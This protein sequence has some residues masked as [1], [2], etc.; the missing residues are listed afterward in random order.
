VRFSVLGSLR[1]E[2]D[3]AVDV[4]GPQVGRLLAAL[5]IDAGRVVTVDRLADIVFAGQPTDAAST[6]LRSYVGRLRRLLVDDGTGVAVVTSR[7]GYRLELGTSTVDAHDFESCLGAARRHLAEGDPAHALTEVD[8]GLALWRGPAYA[9]HADEEWARLEALRLEE[10]RVEGAELRLRTLVAGGRHDAAVADLG[11]FVEEHPLREEAWSALVVA[12]HR[13][14]RQ[15]EALRAAARFRRT[16][17]D[18]GLDPSLAFVAL[19][20]QV[21]QRDPDLDAPAEPARRLRGYRVV[22]ELARGRHGP[23]CLAVQPGVER[24]VVLRSFAA[25]VADH[26]DFIRGFPALVQHVARIDHPHVIPIQDFWREPGAAHLVTRY[27]RGGTAR[28]LLAKGPAPVERVTAIVEHVAGAL[29]AAHHVGL[30]HGALDAGEV[31]FDDDGNAYVDGMGVVAMLDGLAGADGPDRFAVAAASDQRS[32]ADLARHA[33]T[34]EATGASGLLVS[35]ARPELLALDGVFARATAADPADRYPDIVAF[36]RS[37]A[38]AVGRPTP[39]ARL[40]VGNPYKGLR[41]FAEADAGEFFGRDRA[42]AEV[43]GRLAERRF[44]TVVGASGSGK[45][46]VVRAGLVPLVRAGAIAGSEHWYVATM[47][48]GSD[49]F[50]AWDDALGQIAAGGSG[51]A[52]TSARHGIATSLRRAVP[53]GGDVLVVVDQLEELFTLVA[54]ETVRR[55]FIDGL[56]AA[57]E[58]DGSPLRVVATLRADLYD[59]PLGHHRFGGLV[60]GGAV[61]LVGMSASELERAIVG[62]AERAGVTFDGSLVA[63]LVAAVADRPGSLPLLEFTLT[64]LFDRRESAAVTLDD[65]RRIG[66]LTAAIGARAED[67]YRSL[68]GNAQDA[69]RLLFLRLVAV[70][71]EHPDLRRRTTRRELQGIAA[72][73][74]EADRLLDAFGAARLLTFDRDPATREPTVE[75][76][77]EALLRSWPRLAGWI[78]EE[79]HGLEIR[80]DLTVAGGVWDREGRR[81]ADLYR[82]ARL[83]AVEAWAADHPGDLT[84][85]EREYIDAS[86]ASRDAARDAEQ[87]QLERQRRANR[88][89]RVAVAA[90]GVTLVAA[91]VLGLLAVRQRD[92]AVD[93]RAVAERARGRTL[94]T[95]AAASLDDD[96]SLALLLAVEASRLDDSPVTRQALL[97]SLGGDGPFTRTMIPTPATDY[98]ALAVSADERIAA[99]KREDGTVDVIDLDRRLVVATGL[100][101]P[102]NPGAGVDIDP[103]G[104]LVAISGLAS[105][106]GT[107]AIVHDVEGGG[108]VVRIEGD[109]GGIYVAAFTP[110]GET[111]AVAGPGGRIERYRVADWRRQRTL[112]IGDDRA[113]ISFAVTAD[114]ARMVASATPVDGIMPMAMTRLYVIDVATGD[115]IAGPVDTGDFFVNA[116]AVE[117]DGEAVVAAGDRIQ[118]YALDTLEP[119]GEP[120]GDGFPLGYVSVAVSS[121]GVIAAASGLALDIFALD[122]DGGAQRLPVDVPAVGVAVLDGGRSLL[123]ADFEGSLWTWTTGWIDDLGEPLQPEGPGH[124]TLSPD[125]STLAVWGLSR[126]VLLFDTATLELRGTIPLGGDIFLT[127]VEFDPDGRRVATLSCPAADYGPDD[128]C[129]AELGVWDA[130]TASELAGPVDAGPVWAWMEDGTAFTGD[131]Q[132]LVTAEFDGEVQRWDAGAL[133]QVGSPLRLGD[134]SELV[135]NQARIVEAALVAGR[136][137]VAAQSEFGEAVVWDVTSGAAEPVGV[138]GGNISNVGFVDDRLIAAQGAGTFQFRD[139]ETLELVGEP[140]VTDVPSFWFSASDTGLLVSSSRVSGAQLWDVE[141]RQRVSGVLASS[142]AALAPDGSVVYLGAGAPREQGGGDVVRALPIDIAA[143]VAEACERAGRNLTAEEWDR[144]LPAREPHRTTCEQ[145]PPAP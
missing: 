54:D 41:A 40:A 89:L 103:S 52:I 100:A 50:G 130:D 44:V 106:D 17:G 74:A 137:L 114:G 25:D 63:E 140:F 11:R 56:I 4:R 123:T 87:A 96:R 131:G 104:T 18:A 122:D 67:V 70:G 84:A 22:D 78:A 31:L 59:R 92:R 32:L 12:L 86:A 65:Y 94:A 113:I 16:V 47:T 135:G 66:G 125:G 33:L 42:V 138:I 53:G 144:Y 36:A 64:E 108:E 38:R 83:A 112:D 58:A 145:W 34:G 134:V 2:T 77:H 117:A 97:A 71:G 136:S 132:F 127:G 15:T 119:V 45:S 19:E 46:S 69:S 39:P 93:E 35:T 29:D 21:A 120:F 143:L 68:E 90:I 105:E 118:R 121:D 7:P 8:A 61:P 73:G 101:G 111:L 133:E 72:L 1:V 20:R 37:F 141:S 49:P 3:R 82:A 126:G 28:D 9:E 51:A 48:P 110:G 115:V 30:A 99:A 27:V 60:A 102:Q 124:V 88:R 98:S 80:S 10:L 5:L 24:E 116:L 85:P 91:L 142:S 55:A 79:G 139:A 129:P 76:A 128:S 14:G 57:L 75:V 26:P 23:V 62:P 6:T 109:P 43:A 107:A 13:A 81:D 95:A